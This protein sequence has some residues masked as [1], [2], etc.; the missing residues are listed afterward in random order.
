MMTRTYGISPDPAGS[1]ICTS[2][3]YRSAVPQSLLGPSVACMAFEVF[4]VGLFLS[5]R[6]MTCFFGSSRITRRQRQSY[7]ACIFDLQCRI[8]RD[9]KGSGA[10]DDAFGTTRIEPAVEAFVQTLGDR[11]AIFAQLVILRF[12]HPDEV[13]GPLLAH[14]LLRVLPMQL[15]RSRNEAHEITYSR[16]VVRDDCR[17]WCEEQNARLTR[18]H[19]L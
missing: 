5:K 17:S 9:R 4:F 12:R 3:P 2:S 1:V 10:R 19:N 15:L 8:W 11:E 18:I 14:L 7:C 16:R 6:R 13:T